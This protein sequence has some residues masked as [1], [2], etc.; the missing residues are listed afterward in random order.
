MLMMLVEQNDMF[1]AIISKDAT[2]QMVKDYNDEIIDA[3]A[4]SN[5]KNC[6]KRNREED[7]SSGS[8]VKDFNAEDVENS[9]SHQQSRLRLFSPQQ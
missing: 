9:F 7:E 1:N 3:A 4:I 8:F 5:S 6:T 2:R